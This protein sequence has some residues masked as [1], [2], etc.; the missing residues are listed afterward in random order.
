[1]D[2]HYEVSDLRVEINFSCLLYSGQKNV[3][4]PFPSARQLSVLPHSVVACWLRQCPCAASV[5]LFLPS[6]VLTDQFLSFPP[7][8]SEPESGANLS[9]A[10]RL[11]QERNRQ[12]FSWSCAENALLVLP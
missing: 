2:Y 4:N 11:L 1:M 8:T 6:I 7:L 10:G 5:T 3:S 9:L 12:E